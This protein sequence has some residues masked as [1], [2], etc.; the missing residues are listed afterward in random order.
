LDINKLTVKAQEAVIEAQA[1]A[2]Q[3]GHSEFTPEHL[4]TTLVTQEE[5]IVPPILNK[6]GVHPGTV[7]M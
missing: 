3:S 6:L 2:R 1:L 5:G 4:L 7:E